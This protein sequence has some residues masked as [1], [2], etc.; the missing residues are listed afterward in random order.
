MFAP[1]S[2]PPTRLTLIL[3]TA[4]SV[5]T[6]NMFLPALPE[7]AA[8]F[9]VSYG[10][11]SLSIALYMLLGA[12]LGLI[13]GPLADRYGRRTVLLGC[14]AVF[15][16]AS[17]GAALAQSFAAFMAFRLLQAAC[18]A[19]STLSRAI[20]RD[21]YS[22]SKGTSVLG[23]IAMAMAIA[24]MLGPIV[25]GAL[26]QQFSWQA[27]FWTFAIFGIF[28]TALIWS[29]L[30][31]TAPGKGMSWR[32]QVQGYGEVMRSGAFWSFSAVLAFSVSAFFVFLT[33]APF[34][35]AEI[36]GFAPGA[37]GIVLGVTPLGYFMGSFAA[38][39]L[40]ERTSGAA[41]MIWGRWIGLAGPALALALIFIGADTAYVIFG[42]MIT[43]G[44]ANG[45]SMP[46]ASTGTM[47]VRPELAGSASG[48]SMAIATSAGAAFSALTGW[49]LTPDN[50]LAVFIVLVA[51]TCG[52]AVISAHL[53]ARYPE[54]A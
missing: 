18:A 9:G 25:G 51:L 8:E 38:G 40:S 48:L 15:A 35:A 5:L 24:P 31:E 21:M 49:V 42:S 53:A 27:I 36:Y 20:V 14:F 12:V 50:G 54:P 33:G 39:R 6:F 26:Q 45:I 41:M 11:M 2:S 13:L 16:I 32:K 7:M 37:V 28:G 22:P 44:L 19:G 30:G 34:V 1:A 4:I 10:V 23:Y 52:A 29:D 43:I 46:A 47:S 17:I 3:L